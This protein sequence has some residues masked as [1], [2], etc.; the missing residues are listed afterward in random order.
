MDIETQ[1]GQT[2]SKIALQR[3]KELKKLIWDFMAFKQRLE[4]QPERYQFLWASP[5]TEF[6]SEWMTN[7]AGCHDS[8]AIVDCTIFPGLFRSAT[9]TD[10]TVIEKAIVRILSRPT[11]PP[12]RPPEQLPQFSGSKAIVEIPEESSPARDSSAIQSNC[13]MPGSL[14]NTTT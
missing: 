3:T 10:A 12:N 8:D 6:Q 7:F 1:L 14:P 9:P 5:R 11:D 4:C 13:T 2:S